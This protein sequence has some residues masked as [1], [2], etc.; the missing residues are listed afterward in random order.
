[1][2]G[3]IND[4]EQTFSVLNH[5]RRQFDSAFED[6]DRGL[7]VAPL[8]EYYP[9]TNLY[10]TGSAFILTAEMPGIKDEDLKI[11]VTQDVL[12]VT[13]EQKV[14]VPKGY[15]VH[16]RERA[17]VQFSRSYAL[18]ARVDPDRVEAT[19]SNGVLTVTVERAAELKPRQIAVRSS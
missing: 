9:P 16:R 14:D 13:G 19:L 6:L 4:L 1:M 10:D 8:G 7:V 12:T 3:Y 17:P 2:F 5:L 15:S 18:P 11:Q